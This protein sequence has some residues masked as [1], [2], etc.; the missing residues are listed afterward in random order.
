MLLFSNGDT[1]DTYAYIT[2]VAQRQAAQTIGECAGGDDSDL[3]HSKLLY[4][5]RFGSSGN[6]L[7]KEASHRLRGKLPFGQFSLIV[8]TGD[9]FDK[10]LLCGGGCGP[11]DIELFAHG[12]KSSVPQ[13]VFLALMGEMSLERGE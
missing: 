12:E 10:C 8:D 2:S 5:S 1:L 4:E 7:V 3:K 11:R 9:L 6:G 13:P